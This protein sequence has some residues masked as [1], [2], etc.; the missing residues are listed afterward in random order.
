MKSALLTRPAKKIEG[1]LVWIVRRGIRSTRKPHM[2][3]A[4]GKPTM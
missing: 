2:A 4:S 1:T 3:A